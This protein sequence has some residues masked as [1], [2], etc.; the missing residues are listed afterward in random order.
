MMPY[1]KTAQHD[2]HDIARNGMARKGST[3]E[4]EPARN[5][6]RVNDTAEAE[7]HEHGARYHDTGGG[8]YA[9]T[10]L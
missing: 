5:R 3:D 9:G 1:C 6:R 4:R 10:D 2:G 8:A 7:A